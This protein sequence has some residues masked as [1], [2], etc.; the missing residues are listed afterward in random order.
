[1]GGRGSGSK[2]TNRPR[3]T[4]EEQPYT[5]PETNPYWNAGAY[6][7]NQRISQTEQ[8]IKDAEKLAGMTL[9]GTE[10]WKKL[11]AKIKAA[12]TRLKKLQ[13]ERLKLSAA[14]KHAEAEQG[15]DV[16]F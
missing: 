6:A 9:S 11:D 12:R 16:S 7:I 10:V 2:F 4:E 13:V 15:E 14:K 1:M 5:S 3:F 8:Q